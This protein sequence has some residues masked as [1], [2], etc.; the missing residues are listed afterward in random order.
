[1]PGI[2]SIDMVKWSYRNGTDVYER[3]QIGLGPAGLN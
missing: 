1:M 3:M 2:M